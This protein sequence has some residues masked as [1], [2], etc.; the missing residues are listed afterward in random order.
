MSDVPTISAAP[1]AAAPVSH[2]Q[3][4]NGILAEL[5]WVKTLA[6]QP[7]VSLVAS[8]GAM[9]STHAAAVDPDHLFLAM[10][11]QRL[12]DDICFY[13]HAE[14]RQF[15]TMVALGAD[16]AGHPRIVHGG[17]TSALIDETTGGLVF[18]LK[19]AGAL[20][21]GPAFTAHL[22]V[23]FKKPLPVSIPTICTA[24]VD[25]IEGRK[26]W[27]QAAMLDKPGGTVFATGKAL[28]VTPRQEAAAAA[29]LTQ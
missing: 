11:R 24:W 5:D 14:K 6:S 1:A 7:G 10:L 25:S 16:V 29:P 22:E 9:S 4:N 27:V 20:G 3:V 13:Y 28:Y 8:G 19:K 17:F 23:D 18:E 15:H 26:V 2:D 21:P 12:I